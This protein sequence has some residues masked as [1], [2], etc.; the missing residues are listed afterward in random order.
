MHETLVTSVTVG[1]GLRSLPS[2]KT[3]ETPLIPELK[4]PSIPCLAPNSGLKIPPIPDPGNHHS[5]KLRPQETPYKACLLLSLLLLLTRAQE[6]T[7]LYLG[8]GL[9]CC[10]IFMAFLGSRLLGY[11]SLSEL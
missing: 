10:V 7:L 4:I 2:L 6:A 8:W 3:L 11:L 5:S 1:K 9:L